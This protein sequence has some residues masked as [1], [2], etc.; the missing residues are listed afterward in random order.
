MLKEFSF[1]HNPNTSE[2]IQIALCVS[3][4]GQFQWKQIEISLGVTG[5]MSLFVKLKFRPMMVHPS[6]SS[7]M[8]FLQDGTLSYCTMPITRL[9]QLLRSENKSKAGFPPTCG[10]EKTLI[11]LSWT[12]I[13]LCPLNVHSC[14]DLSEGEPVI[15]AIKF[16]L[17]SFLYRSHSHK[18]QFSYV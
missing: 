17:L 4:I 18:V 7:E 14:L 6:T 5:M 2:D 12:I 8:R 10:C 15:S 13:P 1:R 3:F 16:Q 9:Y 11:I